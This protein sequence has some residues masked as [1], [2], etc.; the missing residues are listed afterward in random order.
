MGWDDAVRARQNQHHSSQEES[1]SPKAVT[2]TEPE[3]SCPA[4]GPA[5][6]EQTT[7]EGDSPSERRESRKLSE[8]TNSAL[9]QVLEQMDLP[10]KRR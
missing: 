3:E 6:T 2:E 5:S 4:S 1:T 10:T 7:V 8:Q 9:R